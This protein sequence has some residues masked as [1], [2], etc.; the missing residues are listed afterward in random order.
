MF[1]RNLVDM[2]MANFGRIDSLVLNAGRLDPIG[3]ISNLDNDE[4]KNLFDINF[5]SAIELVKQA[6]PHLKDTANKS[7]RSSSCIFVS[8][9]ASTKPYDGWMAYGASKAALNHLCLDLSVE[10]APL[11]RSI[12]VA[13]GVVDTS[14]QVY[15]RDAG[16]EKMKPEALKRFTDMHKNGEL[17]PPEVPGNVYAELALNGIPDNLNGKFTDLDID[18]NNYPTNLAKD[19]LVQEPKRKY[20]TYAMTMGMGDLKTGNSSS[21]PIPS[22]PLKISNFNIQKDLT[23]RISSLSIIQTINKGLKGRQIEQEQGEQRDQREQRE[24]RETNLVNV[25]NSSTAFK[26]AHNTLDLLASTPSIPIADHKESN[27]LDSHILENRLSRVLNQ[28]NYDSTLRQSLSMIEK[29]LNREEN[30]SEAE[31]DNYQYITSPGTQGLIS[32]RKLRD[33]IEEDI[34]KQHYLTLRGFQPIAEKLEYLRNDLADMNS[35]YGDLN[36]QLRSIIDSSQG[37]RHNMAE[38]TK[39]RDVISIKKNLLSS[40]KA[41]F[42]LNQYEE[43]YLMNE[44]IDEEYFNLL[45]KVSRI[46]SNC[47]ILLSMNNDKLGVSIMTQMARIIDIATDRMASYLK[48]N[49]NSTYQEDT[50]NRDSRTISSL[51]RALIYIRKNSMEKF[52][53]VV[54]DLVENRSRLLSEEFDNQLKGYSEAAQTQEDSR[55]NFQR[56][57]KKT[58]RKTLFMSP[59][60]TKRFASDMLAYVHSVIVNELEM[61]ESLFNFDQAEVE[62]KDLLL[63]IKSVGNKVIDSLSL[64]LR[65]S[66]EGILRQEAKP[67]VVIELYQLLDLYHMMYSKLI[68]VSK[69]ELLNTLVHLKIE[70]KDRLFNMIHVRLKDLKVESGAEEIDDDFLGLPDWLIDFYSNFLVIFEGDDGDMLLGMDKDQRNKVESL[71]VDEPL[72]ILEEQVKKLKL[73]RRSKLIFEINCIDFLYSKIEV[74]SRLSKK[75]EEISEKLQVLVKE[76]SDN[77]FDDLLKHSGLFDIYNLVNMIFALEDDFFDVSLYQPITE[78]KLFNLLTFQDANTKLGDFLATYITSNDLNNLISPTILSQVSVDP[79]LKFVKFYNKLTQIV[80]DD[81]VRS[82]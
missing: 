34:L 61:A 36:Q 3:H 73:S 12:A 79:S 72:K 68:D 27:D 16:R 18:M 59:Y 26:Y 48:K 55:E 60:D 66:L 81:V 17:L 58:S 74:I 20:D 37:V 29:R 80:A 15:I 44:G 13:P 47:D 75:T 39:Q 49:L 2:T 43:H 32:R 14:M 35:C 4:V 42:T 77:L 45:S 78:N 24:Q 9:G 53:G 8:S 5:F 67:G 40:F 69:S 46:H 50:V 30:T 28:N 76:L 19:C 52:N 70:A 64:P 7:N 41:N 1:V 10:E 6:L 65:A 23:K 82:R 71:I 54:A 63:V 62:N 31:A 57:S 56:T 22:A 11:I 21:L 38:E 25:P 33:N 51:Q